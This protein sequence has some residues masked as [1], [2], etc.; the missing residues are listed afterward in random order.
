LHHIPVVTVVV[1]IGTGG[2]VHIAW[3][4]PDGK[5]SIT[6][7]VSIILE[8]K[9]LIGDSENIVPGIGF[10]VDPFVPSIDSVLQLFSSEFVSSG[11][12]EIIVA[13]STSNS[14]FSILKEFVVRQ[15]G[16]VN[17][18]SLGNVFF[19]ICFN[20][21]EI[22]EV[23]TCSIVETDIVEATVRGGKHG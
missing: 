21:F 1:F 14:D 4:I 5:S 11:V 7:V 2:K 8:A 6:D 9:R 22:S 3:S 23:G 17:I 13:L 10:P 19:F 20:I 15:L 16:L 12:D 18:W